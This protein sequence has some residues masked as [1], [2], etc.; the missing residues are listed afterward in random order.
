MALG[1]FFLW[2]GAAA[3]MIAFQGY[4]N[5]SGSGAGQYAGTWDFLGQRI[6]GPISSKVAAS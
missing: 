1:I 4:R 2:I 5:L 6:Y 3:L